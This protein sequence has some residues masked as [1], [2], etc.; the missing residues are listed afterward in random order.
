M[1]EPRSVLITG[2]TGGI[3]AALAQAYAAPGRTLY[4][5]GRRVERLSELATQCRGSG[6][7]V[8]EK[9]LDFADT[10]A[11]IAWC[12]EIAPHIDLAIL[13]AGVTSSTR[14]GEGW[15]EIDHLMQVNLRAAL[16]MC[17][18]LMPAMERRGTGQIAFVSSISA[19]H[20][21]PVTPAYSASKAALKA[22][23]EAL[24]GALAGSGVR[25][26]VVLPGFVRTP[27]S[28]RFPGPKRCM[29]SPQEAASRI[30]RGLARDEPRI[31]FPLLPSL[32][33]RALDLVPAAA[34]QR[35]LRALGYGG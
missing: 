30:V 8:R 2:A 18:V 17:C 15:P 6:A 16:A 12:V 34:A 33:M 7:E 21:L 26:N 20:G 22:Y 19:Y 25:I 27:M 13:N 31:S 9:T 11:T 28:E 23:G 14:A 10:G 4:L 24:R 35:V 1:V 29:L 3:G 5:H 32:F